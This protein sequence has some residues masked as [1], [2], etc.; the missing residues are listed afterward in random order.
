MIMNLCNEEYGLLFKNRVDDCLL[1]HR[2]ALEHVVSKNQQLPMALLWVPTCRFRTI[3]RTLKLCTMSPR[4]SHHQKSQSKHALASG[5]RVP[6]WLNHT[7][8]H[9]PCVS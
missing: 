7:S 8:S 5:V 4:G 1:L 6:H 9:N 3:A 2:Q